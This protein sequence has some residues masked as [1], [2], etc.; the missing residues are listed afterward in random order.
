MNGFF[1]QSQATRAECRE[2]VSVG[3]NFTSSQD[4]KPMLAIKQDAMTGAYKLTYGRVPVKK[5]VFMDAFCHPEFSI[6]KY[7][8]KREH[9]LKVYEG[10]G[11]LSEDRLQSTKL[12][13]LRAKAAASD[14]EPAAQG[15]ADMTDEDDDVYLQIQAELQRLREAR[16]DELVYCGHTMFS[17]LLPDDFEYYLDN[18]ISPV[19]NDKG[20]P[21]PVHITQGVLISGTLNK[22]A[23]GSASASLIHHLWKDYGETEACWFVSMYQQLINFWFQHHGFSVGL[24]DCIPHSTELIKGE[25]QKWFIKAHAFLSSEPDPELKEMKIIHELNKAATLGQKHAKQA[26]KPTNNLVSMIRSGAKGDW[27]NITQVTGLVGQQNVSAQR[28]AKTVGNRCLPHYKKQGKLISDPDSLEEDASVEDITKLFQ[29]RGFVTSCF[30]YGLTPQ[31]FFFHAAGGRE[32]LIDTGIKTADT[33]YSQRKLTKMMEDFRA[34]YS[35]CITNSINNVIQFDY[36]GDNM[37]AS[38]LINASGDSGEKMFSCINVAHVV[39]RLNVQF[40]KSCAL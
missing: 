30:Y 39:E 36:G 38:H 32:G 14:A 18:Q 22:A 35:G 17:F 28:I 16:E 6:E 12:T 37:D 19:M 27:L 7:F 21:E 34:S 20:K 1:A 26:L 8:H 24:E 3:K 33:G 13:E 4:S 40:E 25:M 15:W 2:L 31:E 11:W 5:S 9:V 29:S 10:L 23:M